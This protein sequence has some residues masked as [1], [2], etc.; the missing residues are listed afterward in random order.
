[1]L[2]PNGDVPPAE[3]EEAYYRQITASAL[4]A[5]L[6]RTSLRK[7]RGG[8][9]ECLS[10]SL[11]VESQLHRAVIAKLE[12]IAASSLSASPLEPLRRSVLGTIV[13]HDA[14]HP[15]V[16]HHEVTALG[17]R[18]MVLISTNRGMITDSIKC[19]SYTL[20][21]RTTTGTLHSTTRNHLS[22]HLPVASP[23]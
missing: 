10:A 15:H 13:Y 9:P 16:W 18:P 2:E 5:S 14:F 8:S 21:A 11:L 6:K 3:K 22:I 20:S 7:S 17:T 1:M 23:S 12:S 19:T 4:A